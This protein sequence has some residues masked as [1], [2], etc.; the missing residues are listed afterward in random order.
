[1]K[2][3]FKKMYDSI[4]AM[5]IEALKEKL[6]MY[7]GKFVFSNDGEL[8]N[9]DCPEISVTDPNT[10]KTVDV[11]VLSVEIEDD[12]VSM[13]VVKDDDDMEKMTIIGNDSFPYNTLSF[14]AEEI[15]YPK[16]IWARVGCSIGLTKEQ[17]EK[18]INDKVDWRVSS[19]TLSDA[20]ENGNVWPNGSTYIPE[21]EV[22][23]YNKENNTN[24]EVGDIDIDV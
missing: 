9:D 10:D 7:G 24:F 18:L 3:T 5:E 4:K 23:S 14:V 16:V 21:S 17:A 20:I 2:L 1:M 8:E 13:Q 15:P 22:E 11:F 6:A 19:Q 12:V